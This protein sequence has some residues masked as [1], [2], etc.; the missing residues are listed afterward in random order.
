MIR[1]IFAFLLLIGA[2]IVLYKYGYNNGIN[3][4]RLSWVNVQNKYMQ[5]IN[6]KQQSINQLNESY[7]ILKSDYVQQYNLHK[8]YVKEHKNAINSS[9]YISNDNFVRFIVDPTSGYCEMPKSSNT[10]A[11][12]SKDESA[13]ADRV[14]SYINDAIVH[15]TKCVNQ[16]NSLIDVIG[17]L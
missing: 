10:V 1:N 9:N 8:I 12:A 14:L 13:P 15:D 2:L 17:K 3:T 16:L 5:E 11:T 7:T 4:E 6:V